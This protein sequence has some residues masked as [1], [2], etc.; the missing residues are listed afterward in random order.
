MAGQISSSRGRD[1][2]R[3]YAEWSKMVAWWNIGN[4]I[5]PE[6]QGTKCN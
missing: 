2:Q 5:V 6:N 1:R 3:N 4:R